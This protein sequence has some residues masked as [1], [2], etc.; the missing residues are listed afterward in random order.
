MP[1]AGLDVQ[2]DALVGETDEPASNNRISGAKECGK[3]KG[4][5]ATSE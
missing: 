2:K 4:S 3:E 5:A 1:R